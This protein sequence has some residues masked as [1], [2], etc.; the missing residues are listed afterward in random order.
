[1]CKAFPSTTVVAT[2]AF[3]FGKYS[4][5]K[6]SCEGEPISIR[7]LVGLNKSPLGS[8]QSCRLLA[9]SL[10]VARTSISDYRG[11]PQFGRSGAKTKKAKS[12]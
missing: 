5:L 9:F 7:I 3:G 10:A 1:M 6:T 11:S 8:K 12:L 2:L 4:G